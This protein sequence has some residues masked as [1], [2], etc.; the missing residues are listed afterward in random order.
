MK[1]PAE[2]ARYLAVAIDAARAGAVQ[3]E[4]WRTRFTVKEKERANLVTDADTAAQTA[5][6]A[7]LLGAFADHAFLGE[8]DHFGAAIETMR[9]PAGAPPTWV[10]D[11]LDGTGNYAHG[12]PAY[13]VNI[14]LIVDGA[15]VVAVT[16]DPR[17][18]ELFTATLGGGA[19]LNGEP[20][21]V[22]RTPT[23]RDSLMST[24]F[25]S[26]YQAQLRN[27]TAWKKV[28]YHTQSL[29]RTGSSALNL[30]YVAA[31]R[32]EGYWCY[33]NWP[34]DVVAGALLVTEAG[35]SMSAVDGSSFDPFRMDL[36]GT[37]GHTHA[38]LVAAIHSEGNPDA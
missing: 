8:E 7:C 23:L 5:I 14:G 19:F 2:L 28:S 18:N 15:I 22:S 25:P 27:L 13:C 11:P 37:N 3:L 20:I 31:G 33:D 38:E 9:P 1:T 6:K 10:V 34:W 26:G 24:G 35:G 16:L 32:F 17:L 30:A 21:R 36:I 4:Y 12:V 29:R